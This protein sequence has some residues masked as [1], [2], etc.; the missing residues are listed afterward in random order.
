MRLDIA[1]AYGVNRP[2]VSRIVNDKTH[3]RV[4]ET[5]LPKLMSPEER[6]AKYRNLALHH[7]RD[8]SR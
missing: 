6:A 7:R 4:V 5:D 3:R 2:T 1:R 8:I